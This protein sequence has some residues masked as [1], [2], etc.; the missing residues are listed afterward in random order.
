MGGSGSWTKCCNWRNVSLQLITP[1]A[2]GLGNQAVVP[3]LFSKDTFTLPRAQEP[4]DFC[5]EVEVNAGEPDPAS[6]TEL[7]SLLRTLKK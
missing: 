7:E 4:R 1:N 2:L 6:G 5:R 3:S